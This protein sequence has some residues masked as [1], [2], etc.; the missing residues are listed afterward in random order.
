MAHMAYRLM[1]IIFKKKKEKKKI[2]TVW[3]FSCKLIKHNI[4]KYIKN[5]LIII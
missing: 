3:Y 4:N 1:K 2:Y 5:L